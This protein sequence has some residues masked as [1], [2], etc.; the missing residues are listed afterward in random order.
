MAEKFDVE[1][2]LKECN[3]IEKEVQTY[4]EDAITSAKSMVESTLKHILG[5]EGEKFNNN[6]TLRVLYKK[7]SNIM[8]LSLGRYNENT[9]KTILSGMVNVINGLDEVRNEYVDAHGKS[10]KN[11]KPETSHAFLAINTARTTHVE[12]RLMRQ[13]T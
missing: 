8:N 2:V 3:R 13:A 5:S 11:Y 10:K 12:K 6:E 4:P 1:Y 9:F 7:V